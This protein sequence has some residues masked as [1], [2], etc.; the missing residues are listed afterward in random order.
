MITELLR[1]NAAFLSTAAA[2]NDE[3]LLPLF[4]WFSRNLLLAEAHNRH[5]RLAHSAE[6]LKDSPSSDRALALLRAAESRDLRRETQ[7]CDP[8]T[9]IA[10]SGR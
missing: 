2:T 7:D 8:E 9:V 3:T 6:M 5:L 1:P 4:R 10:S